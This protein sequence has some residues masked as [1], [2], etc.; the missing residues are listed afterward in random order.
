M[1]S[2]ILLAF[3]PLDGSWALPASLDARVTS[4]DPQ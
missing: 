4:L 1:S 3:L 2:V